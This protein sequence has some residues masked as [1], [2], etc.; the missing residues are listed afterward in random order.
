MNMLPAWKEMKHL[1][2]W[3]MAHKWAWRQEQADMQL[4]KNNNNQRAKGIKVIFRDY[5]DKPF[6]I[7]GL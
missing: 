2:S 5:T 3:T 1:W 6:T 7:N 4:K